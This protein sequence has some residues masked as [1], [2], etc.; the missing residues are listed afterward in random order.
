MKKRFALPVLLFVFIVPTLKIGAQQDQGFTPSQPPMPKQAPTPAPPPAPTG[1]VEVNGIAA[2]VNGSV[3]TKNQVSFLIAPLFRQLSAQFPRRGPQFENQLKEAKDKVVRELV[4]RQIILDEFK[5]LG[6]S[7]KPYIIDAEIKRQM[8]ELYNGDEAKFREELK[9]SRL[10]MEG[11]REMT[12]EKMVV[13]AM[14]AQ[15]FSD[16]PPPLPAEVR[17]EY[18]EVKLSIR[19]VTK[20]LITFQKIFIPTSD[21]QNPVATPETQL[22]LAEDVAK[23]AADGK[24]FG[25]LAKTYSKD[26]FSDKMGLQENVPRADLS[27]EFAAIIFDA[28]IGS[29]VGPLMDQQGF[30]LVKPIKIDYGPSPDLSKVREMIE[31]R[32]TKKKTSVQYERWIESR[33]KRAMIEIKI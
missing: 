9:H 19:D 25:E 20:D 4:D 11:Y 28:K 16:A 2:K 17:K 18:E 22:A 6:A 12:R 32:V 30:T 33:R 31:E 1:P 7:I 27:P 8:R 24:D 29:I 13:Q 21:S 26:A 14:R 5:Q 15:Q 23:Q 10:T 3:V